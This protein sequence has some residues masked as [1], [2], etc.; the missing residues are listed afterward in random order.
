MALDPVPHIRKLA[1][2]E[3]Y[4]AE[5]ETR[6][7]A[8]RLSYVGVGVFVGLLAFTMLAL[9]GFLALAEIYGY[10]LAALITGVVL[11]VITGILLIIASREPNRADKLEVE[12]AQR[13]IAE[14]RLELRRDYDQAERALNDM[15]FGLVGLMKNAGGSNVSLF[16]ILLGIAAAFIPSLR[17]ILASF[18]RK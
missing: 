10:P 1:E 2:A 16:A 14:A 8:K 18:I 5:L 11:A 3:L 4:R 15:T 6:R 17:K 9:S 12:L 7:L 13:A